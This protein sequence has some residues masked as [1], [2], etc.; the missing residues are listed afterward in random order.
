MARNGTII[1]ISLVSEYSEFWNFLKILG[2]VDGFDGFVCI[3][4]GCGCV[5]GKE[6]VINDSEESDRILFQFRDDE[7]FERA[8][9]IFLEDLYKIVKFKL[10]FSL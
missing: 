7:A 6:Y 10:K 3:K 1:L 5:K 9:Y 4:M 2:G 8:A